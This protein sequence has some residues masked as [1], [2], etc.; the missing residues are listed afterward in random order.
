MLFFM[1]LAEGTGG[2][3]AFPRFIPLVVLPCL[4]KYIC[5]LRSQRLLEQLAMKMTSVAPVIGKRGG[6]SSP[7]CGPRVVPPPSKSTREANVGMGL[8]Q[9]P[10]RPAL[11][12]FETKGPPI[13]VQSATTKGGGGTKG[14]NMDNPDAGPAPETLW[15]WT[16][17]H[18]QEPT[19]LC[20]IL[21]S[22]FLA[23]AE[24]LS[25]A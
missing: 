2:L 18:S 24:K 3:R 10:P 5:V 16:R 17:H 19:D 12:S 9:L 22:D 11:Q 6:K 13:I 15:L 23:G 14:P 21:L 7:Y 8:Q 25:S 4:L 20:R 1:F